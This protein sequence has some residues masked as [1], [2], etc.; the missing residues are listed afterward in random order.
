[1]VE[2]QHRRFEINICGRLADNNSCGGNITTVCDVTDIYRPRV[3][4]VGYSKNDQLFY[5]S[6]SK[7]LKLI[8]HQRA[9]RKSS[10][11]KTAF[12]LYFK[13]NKKSYH[14]RR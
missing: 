4:A 8:Q 7:H 6:E 13:L 14:F 12:N 5:D 9:T 3:Y 11:A 2:N 10:Y 1:M